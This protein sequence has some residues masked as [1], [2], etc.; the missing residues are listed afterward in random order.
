MCLS[1][2]KPY[3]IWKCPESQIKMTNP[4]AACRTANLVRRRHMLRYTKPKVPDHKT[5]TGMYFIV[6]A[7]AYG[8]H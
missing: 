4:K 1:P 3:E 8:D 7:I 6:T 2:L 5:V